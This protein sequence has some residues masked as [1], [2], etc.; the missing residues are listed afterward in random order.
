MKYAGWSIFITGLILSLASWFVALDCLVWIYRRQQLKYQF[1]LG[2]CNS[3]AIM[4]AVIA[5]GGLGLVFLSR[6]E[7]QE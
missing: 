1:L 3:S 5:V 7:K 4:F 6:K 2:A